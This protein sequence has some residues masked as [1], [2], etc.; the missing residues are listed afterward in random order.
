MVYICFKRA[1]SK[2]DT[3]YR[4]QTGARRANSTGWL[5]CNTWNNLLFGQMGWLLSTLTTS[6]ETKRVM[7]PFALMAQNK[8]HAPSTKWSLEI[9]KILS[10]VGIRG[11]EG[12][13]FSSKE[14]FNYVDFTFFWVSVSY[15]FSVVTHLMDIAHL[16]LKLNRRRGC[17]CIH[18]LQLLKWFLRKIEYIVYVLKRYTN[19][20]RK[21][22]HHGNCFLP[23]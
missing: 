16:I 15:I 9:I 10:T 2:I 19:Y 7:K 21:Y 18:F 4:E 13:G 3:G 11:R 17:I 14:L 20:T 6:A 8:F 23:V 12:G 22:V 1:V 5:I